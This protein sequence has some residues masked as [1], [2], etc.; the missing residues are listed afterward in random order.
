MFLRTSPLTCQSKYILDE[1]TCAHMEMYEVWQGCDFSDTIRE[2][3]CGG[4]GHSV[5][6]NV[7]A[8]SVA[9]CFGQ[10]SSRRDEYKMGELICRLRRFHAHIVTCISTLTNAYTGA[11]IVRITVI[12]ANIMCR[13]MS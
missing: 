10:I 9:Q 3:Y 4:F 13:L 1:R 6:T 12:T 7:S 5:T 11:M 2:T 8:S